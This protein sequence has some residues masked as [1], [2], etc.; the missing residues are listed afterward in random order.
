MQNNSVESLF[1]KHPNFS[2]A[3]EA[4]ASITDGT[5]YGYVFGCVLGEGG[6]VVLQV[7]SSVLHSPLKKSTRVEFDMRDFIMLEHSGT[8][9]LSTNGNF[10]KWIDLEIFEAPVSWLSLQNQDNAD[11]EELLRYGWYLNP[12]RIARR[13]FSLKNKVD[14]LV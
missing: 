4:I 3:T 11:L 1:T 8:Y 6:S 13:V 7:F 5:Y 14:Y 2:S 10:E 12:A 9:L